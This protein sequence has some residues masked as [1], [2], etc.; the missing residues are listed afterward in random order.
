MNLILLSHLSS[1]YV[2]ARSLYILNISITISLSLS[3]YNKGLFNPVL[4]L[5]TRSQTC[6]GGISHLNLVSW[7]LEMTNQ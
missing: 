5:K 6:V 4:R 2:G 7:T 3:T 1:I